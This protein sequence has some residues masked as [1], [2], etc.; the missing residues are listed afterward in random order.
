MTAILA[1]LLAFLGW[2]LNDA[3]AIKLFRSNDP[4]KITVASGLFRAIGWLVLMPLFLSEIS[5]ITLTPLIYNLIAGF[6]SGLGYYL[7]GL[8]SKKT[9]PVIVAS[10]TGGWG[11]STVL[12]GVLFFG[13]TINFYQLLSIIAV[14]LGLFLVTFKLE[15][16]TGLRAKNDTGLWYAF[17]AFLVW[18]FCGAFLKLPAISYGWYWTSLIM[19]IPYLSL[20]FLFE[21]KV[22]QNLHNLKINNF[23]LFIILVICIILADLGYNSSFSFGGNIAIVGTISGSYAVLSTVLAYFL[24]KEPLSKQQLIGVFLT[25][26]GII[27][28]A[29]ST[30]TA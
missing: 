3:L 15:Y 2:G 23:R 17:G 4:A 24:Y 11:V 22:S 28:T 9:N 14:F 10:I 7:F 30:S 12:L 25:L 5:K 18:G 1:S 21:K 8:A 13:E 20:I 6:S 19:L 27:G 26:V 29:I 16:I